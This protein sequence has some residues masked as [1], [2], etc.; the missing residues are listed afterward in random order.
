MKYLYGLADSRDILH[1]TVFSCAHSTSRSPKV[2]SRTSSLRRLCELKSSFHDCSSKLCPRHS[3]SAGATFS[4]PL[5]VVVRSTSPIYR[6]R[7]APR[8]IRHS[9]T[10]ARELTR[11]R[12]VR[13][14]ILRTRQSPETDIVGDR[15]QT[16]R[17]LVVAQYLNT[18]A[19]LAL[20]GGLLTALAYGRVRLQP[21]GIASAL[22]YYTRSLRIFCAAGALR[23]WCVWKPIRSCDSSACWTP[24]LE[25]RDHNL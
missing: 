11:N 9:R 3:R 13:P 4:Q 17:L 5:F 20:C 16:L 8:P 23:P 25:T 2:L 12:L 1:W 22:L 24:A 21:R 19:W 18:F 6:G 15:D 10:S 7:T 14:T